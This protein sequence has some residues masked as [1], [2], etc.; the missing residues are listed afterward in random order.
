MPAGALDPKVERHDFERRLPLAPELEAA[1]MPLLVRACFGEL[2][3][4][5]PAETP[6]L[7]GRQIPIDGHVKSIVIID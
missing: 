5:A 6:E 4:A 7:P 1:G 3:R 2:E